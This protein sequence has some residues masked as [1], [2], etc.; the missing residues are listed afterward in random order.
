MKFVHY[1]SFLLLLVWA[2]ACKNEPTHSDDSST[3]SEMGKTGNPTIDNISEKIKKHPDDVSLYVARAQAFYRLEGYDEAILDMNHAIK[4]DTTQYEYFLFLSDIL[5]DYNRSKDAIRVVNAAV[6][7]FPD[8]TKCLLKQAEIYYMLKQYQQSTAALNA[9]LLRDNQNAQ[10]FF[11]FGQNFKE[12]GDT[13]RAIKSY[14]QAVDLDPDI[15]DAWIN[16]GN[17]WSDKGPSIARKYYETAI[18]I[19]TTNVYALNSYALFLGNQDKLQ[20]SIDV[21]KKIARIDPQFSDGFFNAG[22]MYLTMDS[23]KQ[24]NRQFDLAVKTNPTF[25]KAYYYRG[26]TF[27]RMDVLD[28]AK[29]NYEQALKFDPNLQRAKDALEAF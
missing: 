22:I 12:L 27:E 18:S 10:A 9:L 23:V 5:L 15:I 25:A 19:D 1:L 8:N 6:H 16:L 17:L 24:A 11:L 7:R 28:K 29:A 4:M 2:V 3:P 14:Q 26:Y 21:Y 20:Q 13:T